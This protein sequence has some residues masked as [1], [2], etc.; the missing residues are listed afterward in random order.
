[1][2]CKCN[3]CIFHEYVITICNIDDNSTE[4]DT[5]NKSDNKDKEG[6]S[7]TADTNNQSATNDTEI[8]LTENDKNSNEEE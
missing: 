8:V 5:V 1:M 3:N 6:K 7:S 2:L 4:K